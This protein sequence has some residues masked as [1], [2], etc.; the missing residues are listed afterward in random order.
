MQESIESF[1]WLIFNG[2]MREGCG[3]ARAQFRPPRPRGRGTNGVRGIFAAKTQGSRGRRYTRRPCR[4]PRLPFSLEAHA[5][6]T[7]PSFRQGV[8]PAGSFLAIQHFV[9]GKSAKT[10]MTVQARSAKPSTATG[11]TRTRPS[12]R[13]MGRYGAI[14]TSQTCRG[15]REKFSL[16]GCGAA[17]HISDK[18]LPN[19][20]CAVRHPFVISEIRRACFVNLRGSSCPS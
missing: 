8:V 19:E 20:P 16:P 13:R 2:G 12:G 4:L 14:G 15:C 17:P 9:L 1:Q 18:Q 7:L 11:T 6:K 5:E 3:R 10:T